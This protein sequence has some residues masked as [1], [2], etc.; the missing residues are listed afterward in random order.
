[1]QGRQYSFRQPR[2]LSYNAG[3][4]AMTDVFLSYA[5]ASDWRQSGTLPDYRRTD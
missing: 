1:M 4:G 5:R 3:Q 2:R